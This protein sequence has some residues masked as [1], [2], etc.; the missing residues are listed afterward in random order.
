M[1]RRWYTVFTTSSSNDINIALGQLGS[2]K[3]TPTGNCNCLQKTHLIFLTR[4]DIFVL[5]SQNSE[6]QSDLCKYDGVL[7]KTPCVLFV[8]TV[9]Y[10]LVTQILITCM[11][12]FKFSATS[13]IR[14]ICMP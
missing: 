13:L 5:E 14:D 6:H 9:M 12:R 11:E 3:N 7:Q 10:E 8:F 1:S 4:A 2:S